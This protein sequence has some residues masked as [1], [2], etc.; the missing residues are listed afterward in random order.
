MKANLSK[1]RQQF[2]NYESDHDRFARSSGVGL[3]NDVDDADNVDNGSTSTLVFDWDS[4]YGDYD[5]YG[6]IYAVWIKISEHGS[7][8]TNI[9]V[10]KWTTSSG[11]SVVIDWEPH[12]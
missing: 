10:V 6:A 3:V 1:E 8:S 2:P 5:N 11:P 7:R 4:D 9:P 12:Y